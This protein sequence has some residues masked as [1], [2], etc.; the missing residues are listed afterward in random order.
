VIIS[1]N[2]IELVSYNE[3]VI[4]SIYKTCLAQYFFHKLLHS[5]HNTNLHVST[6]QSIYIQKFY[7][8]TL[9]KMTALKCFLF[10]SDTQW[11]Q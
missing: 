2:C 4:G 5:N 7:Q 3:R 1:A 9:L 8:Y 10:C 6:I 11:T